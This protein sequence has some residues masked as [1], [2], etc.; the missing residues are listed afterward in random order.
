MKDEQHDVW[1]FRDA[2]SFFRD[3]WAEVPD[4]SAQSRIMRP[5]T[6]T[7]RRAGDMDGPEKAGL[8][9]MTEDKCKTG[10]KEGD[11]ETNVKKG[12][13]KRKSKISAASATY[14]STREEIICCTANISLEIPYLCFS[15]EYRAGTTRNEKR[16]K[17]ENLLEVY[18]S[19]G[20]HRSPT[21]DEWY[22]HFE[23][24]DKA[25][26][27]KDHRNKTQVVTKFA[28]D[29]DE[30]TEH[31]E[32]PKVAKSEPDEWILLRVNQLWIWTFADSR[33][34]YSLKSH[35][36]LICMDRMADNRYILL[37]G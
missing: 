2:R 25:Q 11:D 8:R 27:D 35:A 18:N 26:E 21:L 37:V 10:G 9:D 36:L 14:V 17:Y 33:L 32:G 34:Y 23:N 15:T 29:E 7:K 13:H 19:S 22:Y 6:V 24:G 28:K 5:R 12:S 31:P 3:S 16:S 1:Q 20:N 30:S 4:E